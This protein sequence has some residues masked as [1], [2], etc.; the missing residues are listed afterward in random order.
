LLPFK[1]GMVP[2]LWAALQPLSTYAKSSQEKRIKLASECSKSRLLKLFKCEPS[3]CKSKKCL[4]CDRAALGFKCVIKWKR[5]GQE[6]VSS[7]ALGPLW[8]SSCAEGRAVSLPTTAMVWTIN[9]KGGTIE[10]A[11]VEPLRAG[12]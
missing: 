8:D 9:I 7:P 10:G 4:T 5:G 6:R 12:A 3:T 1:W 2:F 11:E